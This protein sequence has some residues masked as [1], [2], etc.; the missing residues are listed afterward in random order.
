MREQRLR[1]PVL[2]VVACLQ[3]IQLVCAGAGEGDATAGEQ[4]E[5]GHTG[6]LSDGW[7]KSMGTPYP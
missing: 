7:G 1:L 5:A 3:D 6:M 2:T 4:G